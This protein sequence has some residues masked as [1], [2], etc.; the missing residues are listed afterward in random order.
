[1]CFENVNMVSVFISETETWTSTNV[2][3]EAARIHFHACTDTLY[4]CDFRMT[5]VLKQILLSVYCSTSSASD[6]TLRRDTDRHVM[7]QCCAETPSSSEVWHWFMATATTHTH[8]HGKQSQGEINPGVWTE[9]TCICR[10]TSLSRHLSVTVKPFG[11]STYWPHSSEKH[12]STS[13]RWT[14]IWCP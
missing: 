13:L 11:K 12:W 14:S 7:R 9:L 3:R 5:R 2:K 10:G 1:M 8:F 4:P 6:D